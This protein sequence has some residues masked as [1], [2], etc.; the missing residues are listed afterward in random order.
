MVS[1][2]LWIHSEDIW[3]GDLRD[4]SVTA[5]KYFEDVQVQI[6]MNSVLAK[7]A[8]GVTNKTKGLRLILLEYCNAGDTGCFPSIICHI[9]QQVGKHSCIKC[10]YLC[11]D[12]NKNNALNAK[13]Y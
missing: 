5:T 11:N 4:S 13:N 10:T 12:K 9:S 2:F 3:P 7:E 8:R 6:V 1:T